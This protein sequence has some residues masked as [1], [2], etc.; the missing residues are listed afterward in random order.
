MQNN[1]NASDYHSLQST[2]HQQ[3]KRL[4]KLLIHFKQSK[5]LMSAVVTSFFR[6]G[7]ANVLADVNSDYDI[8]EQ[9]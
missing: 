1:R 7:K 6:F 3:Q 4:K 8:D 2:E 9:Y 5:R